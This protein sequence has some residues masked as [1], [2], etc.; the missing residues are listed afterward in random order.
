MIQEI[1]VA[2]IAIIICSILIYKL[3]K[4]FFV[5]DNNQSGCNCSGCNCNPSSNKQSKR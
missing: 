1:I 5:K 4:F 3:Y 2:T